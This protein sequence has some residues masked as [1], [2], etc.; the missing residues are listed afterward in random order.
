MGPVT[1]H[2][3]LQAIHLLGAAAFL[4]VSCLWHRRRG[5]FQRRLR[6]RRVAGLCRGC[7]EG[8][9]R[10]GLGLLRVAGGPRRPVHPRRRLPLGHM[11]HALSLTLATEQWAP[12]SGEERREAIR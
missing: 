5:H 2:V 6:A 1:A 3:I 9:P 4:P 8:V 11:P 10:L 12:W 7:R